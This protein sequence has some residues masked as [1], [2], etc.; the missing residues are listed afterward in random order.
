MIIEMRA[1]DNSRR[2]AW[3]EDVTFESKSCD[4]SDKSFS[5]KQSNTN[6]KGVYFIEVTSQKA[7]TYPTLIKCPLKIYVNKELVEDF[8]PEQGVSP[9][10]ILI[11]K[12]LEKF[13]KNVNNSEVL[14][15]GNADKEYVFEVPLYDQYNNLP[16]TFQEVVGI[17]IDYKK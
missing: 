3:D 2:N 1:K 17:K 8:N 9:D 15:D 16:E 7:N 13:F 11:T 6:T 10:S 12:I 4:E 5:F 14:L